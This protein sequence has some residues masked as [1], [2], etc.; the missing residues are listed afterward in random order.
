VPYRLCR[1]FCRRV[2][3][4]GGFRAGPEGID[5]RHQPSADRSSTCLLGLEVRVLAAQLGELLA[6]AAPALA[7]HLT[8]RVFRLADLQFQVV[9]KGARETARCPARRLF[10]DDLL[11]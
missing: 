2:S 10:I 1:L 3:G 9:P 8:A 5:L 6:S 7:G 4:P 11:L